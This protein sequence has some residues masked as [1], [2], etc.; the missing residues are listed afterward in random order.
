MIMNKKNNDDIYNGITYMPKW[1]SG[2][3]H[4]CIAFKKDD[5]LFDFFNI[6]KYY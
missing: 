4:F 2:P 6:I 1:Q 3:D 5:S